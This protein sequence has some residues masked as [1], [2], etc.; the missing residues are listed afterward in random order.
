[1]KVSSGWAGRICFVNLDS[2]ELREEETARYAEEYIGGRG[3][4]ARI[5][6]DRLPGGVD[7]F[8]PENVLLIMTGPLTGTLAP[9]SGRTVFAG[10]SPR[11]FPRPWYT[12]ST[13]GGFFGS[14]L[15]YAGFD[16]L[17]IKG[18]AE[19]PAYVLV[20][21]GKVEVRG[22][23]DIWGLGT[24]STERRMK[25]RHGRRAQVVSIGPAGEN[26]VRFAAIVSHSPEAASGHSGFGAVMGS[27][28]L[29]AVV[30][31]GSSGVA[32]ADPKGFLAACRRAMD[33]SR[34]GMV[35]SIAKGLE[36]A[37]TPICTHACNARC[38]LG[39]TY[40]KVA[41]RFGRGVIERQDLFC[42]GTIW[43]ESGGGGFGCGIDLPSV[44]GWKPEEGGVE[45]HETCDDLGLDLWVLLTLQPWFE[46]CAECGVKEIGGKELRPRDAGWFRELLS[47]IARRRGIGDILAEDLRRAVEKMGREL[48]APA[49]EAAEVL[50][51]AF[52]FP[53]HRE[54]RVWDHEPLPFWAVSAIMY[55]TESRD[56]TIGTH[57][58]LQ[59]AD[60]YMRD[61]AL[62]L[63]KLRPLARSVWGSEQA[64]EPSFE[65]KAQVAV[66]CQNRHVLIDSLPLCDFVFPRLIR[67]FENEEAWREAGE[68]LGDLDVEA[69]LF[70]TCTGVEMDSS[71]LERA[72][73]RTFNLERALLARFGR[74][75]SVDEA[76]AKHFELPCE[77]DGTRIDEG[78][79]R[80]MMDEYYAARGWDGVSGM[81]N[82]SVLERLGLGGVAESLGLP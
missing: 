47:D 40:K 60:L 17:V 11:V 67:P 48:P 34:T 74:D 46:R 37:P 49:V 14:E 68:V 75:R 77:S 58:Y 63:E 31:R 29:K 55:A 66:W 78:A 1:M 2:G 39:R 73:E 45:L 21:D 33:S 82:R 56:P 43:A 7:A 41:R 53:S 4:A 79:F 35:S 10:V 5:A 65:A 42:V 32:I 69:E 13:M 36:G 6:W 20:M 15:K 44:R 70:S 27:K 26:L 61:P 62:A 59:I 9:T 18:R 16:G 3:F 25:E 52:G 51:F 80:K 23:E 57:G 54:G 71:E 76:V 81:P 64:A 19:R 24:H 30:A 38:G 28:N 8:A 22:A 50:E 72:A 12:H